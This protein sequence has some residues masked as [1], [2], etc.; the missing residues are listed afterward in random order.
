MEPDGGIGLPDEILGP[1]LLGGLPVPT[2]DELMPDDLQHQDETCQLLNELEAS[3]ER[4][5]VPPPPGPVEPEEPVLDE[6]W[7]YAYPPWSSMPS[8][9]AG[10]V[11]EVV[12]DQ[13]EPSGAPT[14]L[15][16]LPPSRQRPATGGSAGLKRAGGQTGTSGLSW[17]PLRKEFV[18]VSEELCG[19]CQYY[20]PAGSGAEGSCGYYAD[21]EG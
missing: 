3:I 4:T 9:G 17:C 10:N 6:G 16:L 7:G 19:N 11:G 21:D 14:H 5:V 13:G 18:A 20:E 1:D 2:P 8:Q 15:G 12:P